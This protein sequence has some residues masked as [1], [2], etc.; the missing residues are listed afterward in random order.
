MLPAVADGEAV[1]AV[2]GFGPPTIEDR[3]VEPAVEHGLHT[4]R[5]GGF[6]WP[7]RSVQPNVDPLHQVPG[8][9]DVVIFD[10]REAAGEAAVVAEVFNL[11]DEILA[12]LVGR[13]GLAGKD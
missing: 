13:M 9:V 10:E 11:L 8:D 12:G 5:A 7:A 6:F 3:Q 1:L 4:T 2:V